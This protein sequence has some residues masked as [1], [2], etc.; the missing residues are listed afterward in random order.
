MMMFSAALAWRHVRA[1]PRRAL[2]LAVRL[3]LRAAPGSVRARFR[4]LA[5]PAPQRDDRETA[6][7]RALLADALAV[8]VPATGPERGQRP[9][10]S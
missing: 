1:D 10:H 5:A 3:A 2:R 7:L 4:S 8:R 6:D 9:P